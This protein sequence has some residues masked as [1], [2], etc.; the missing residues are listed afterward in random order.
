D[1]AQNVHTAY[2]VGNS[3]EI[4]ADN[5]QHRHGTKDTA[6]GMVNGSENTHSQGFGV[7]TGLWWSRNGNNLDYYGKDESMVIKSTVLQGDSRVASVHNIRYPMAGMKSE[8]VSLVVF[9]SESKEYVTLQAGEP[10]EEYLTGVTWDPS[11]EFVYVGVLN[12][13]Q[14]HLKLNQYNAKTGAYVK[15]LYEEKSSSWVEPQHDLQFLP[16]NKNQ[17][18]YQTDRD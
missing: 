17:F 9:N 14:D 5:G 13:G 8:E 18:L 1:S 4:L 3:I 10:K 2:L 15:T 12:R 16:N 11:D 6:E 7:D